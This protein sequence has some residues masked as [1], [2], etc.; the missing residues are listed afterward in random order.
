MPLA[1]T[2]AFVTDVPSAV[3]EDQLEPMECF[4]F[5]SSAHSPLFYIFTAGSFKKKKKTFSGQFPA[6][7]TGYP[8]NQLPESEATQPQS[9]VAYF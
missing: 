2:S 5:F 9:G 3:V 1:S 7:C 6:A 4:F 8:A